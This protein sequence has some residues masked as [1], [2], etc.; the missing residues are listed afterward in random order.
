MLAQKKFQR[1]VEDF[2]CEKCGAAVRG[3][4]YTDHCP[5]CLWGKHVDINPGD[6][7]ANCHGKM[8]PMGIE[9]KAKGIAIL[10]ECEKC[11]YKYKVKKAEAD[12][13]ENILELIAGSPLK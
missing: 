9:K 1:K 4:G 3:D 12:S 11:G 13:M 5:N 6:R 7:K 2:I 8:K 10:Y